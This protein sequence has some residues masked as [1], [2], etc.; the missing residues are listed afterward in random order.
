MN[1]RRG[2]A[3]YI[4]LIS[5]VGNEWKFDH[6]AKINTYTGILISVMLIIPL[7]LDKVFSTTMLAAMDT[8]VHGQ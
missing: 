3:I 8:L 7:V 6:F 5:Y 2:S 4:S 1:L